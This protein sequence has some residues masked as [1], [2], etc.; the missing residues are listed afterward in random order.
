[1]S[2]FLEFVERLMPKTVVIENVA[3]VLNAYEGKVR[4]EITQRLEDL[5]YYVE[6]NVLNAAWYGVP[7]LRRRAFFVASRTRQRLFL[8]LPT[9][10]ANGIQPKLH[11]LVSPSVGVWESIGDLPSLP[12]GAGTNPCPYASPPFTEYQRVMRNGTGRP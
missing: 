10:A 12:D 8:P 5:G 6:S 3:E 2:V 7:Q 11:G 9:H 1:M 4:D